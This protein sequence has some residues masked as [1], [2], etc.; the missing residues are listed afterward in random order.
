[1]SGRVIQARYLGGRPGTQ[2]AQM[3]APG[4]PPLAGTLQAKGV[5]KLPGA[6]NLPAHALQAKAAHNRPGTPAPPPRALQAHGAAESFA[7]DPVRLGLGQG[8]GNPLPDAV[9]AKMEAAFGTDFSRVRVHEGPQAARIGAIAFTTGHDIYFAPGQYRPETVQGQQLLGHELAHVVQQ[10]QGRVTAPGSGVSVVQ[11]HALEAEADRLG[12]RAAL[13]VHAATP[14]ANLSQRNSSIFIQRSVAMPEVAPTLEQI[15]EDIH[16][17]CSRNGRALASTVIA[18]ARY[19]D[20]KM[21]CTANDISRVDGAAEL[22]REKHGVEGE[23]YLAGAGFHAEMWIVLNEL[24]NIG[25]VEEIGASRPCSKYC[26][27]IL[28]V[29][30][31]RASTISNDLFKSWYNPLT[32]DNECMP[33]ADFKKHQRQDIPDYRSRGIDYWWTGNK[34]DRTTTPP[35]NDGVE[36][37]INA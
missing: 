6:P 30:N 28:S 37:E 17:A 20:G 34:D 15:A 8:R 1:M 22:V 19:S 18:V 31:I 9:R 26:S 16:E 2:L 13:K 33:K 12:M 25:F 29:L 11:D 23:I 35:N 5:P 10:R 27:R 24:D 21:L 14:T 36:E 3:R 4:A 32:V 7:V